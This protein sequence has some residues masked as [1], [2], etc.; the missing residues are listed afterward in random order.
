MRRHERAYLILN[1]LELC[2]W[3][4]LLPASR[5]SSL[6]ASLPASLVLARGVFVDRMELR[7]IR[8]GLGGRVRG[9]G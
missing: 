9:E 2:A 3:R 8:A 6:P 4:A 5:L 1:Q 7:L